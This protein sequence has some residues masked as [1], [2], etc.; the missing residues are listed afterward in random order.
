MALF[1]PEAL[2]VRGYMELFVQKR[3]MRG[4]FESFSFKED[5][6]AARRKGFRAQELPV[7]LGRRRFRTEMLDVRADKGVDLT[8]EHG[9]SGAPGTAPEESLTRSGDDGD[10]RFLVSMGDGIPANTAHHSALMGGGGIIVTI[11][12]AALSGDAKSLRGKGMCAEGGVEGSAPGRV[13][14][15]TMASAGASEGSLRRPR[16]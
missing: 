1:R 7:R 9:A 15:V 16:G 3:I 14:M 12:T 13:T 2:C 8:A 10:D 6:C 4:R 5:S 11:V